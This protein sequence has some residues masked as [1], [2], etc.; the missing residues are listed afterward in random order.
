M[1]KDASIMS[2]LVYGLKVKTWPGRMPAWPSR[3]NKTPP[4]TTIASRT[5]NWPKMQPC[6]KNAFLYISCFSFQM[7]KM[8]NSLFIYIYIVYFKS[9]QIYCATIIRH[10][11]T[12]QIDI[13]NEW[14]KVTDELSWSPKQP[15]VY[16][17][18]RKT[19]IIC[20]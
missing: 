6:T 3:K 19:I 5:W 18:S 8:Y 10:N 9:N 7:Y 1:V 20:K 12:I 2:I 13:L 4:G 11:F 14:N 16:T 17:Y 15:M